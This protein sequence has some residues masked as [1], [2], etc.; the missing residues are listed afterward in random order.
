MAKRRYVFS[1]LIKTIAKP[2]V[3]LRYRLHFT[4]DASLKH[5]KRPYFIFGNHPSFM[6]PFFMSLGHT[7][8]INFVAN[9]EYFRFKTINFLLK[10]TGAIPKTKFL[11]DAVA[12]R[13][14]FRLK[15]DGSAIGVYPEG[16]RT[17][18]GKTQPLL[19]PTARL[20][21]KMGIPVVTVVTRGASTSLPR[22]AL[23]M[24]K[25]KIFLNYRLLLT[26]EQIADMTEQE[27]YAALQEA[28]EHDEP[29]WQ[30]ERMIPYKGKKLAERLEWFLYACPSCGGIETMT[31]GEDLYSCG[32]CGYTVRYNEFGFFEHPD[33]KAPASPDNLNEW[34]ALQY[35]I[36]RKKV[37]ELKPGQTLLHNPSATLFL[38]QRGK[39]MLERI[40]TG[41]LKLT[42]QGFTLT[43]VIGVSEIEFEQIDT[44]TINHK[45]TI[46][47]YYKGHKLRITLDNRLRCGYVWEC[48]IKA[49][50][51]NLEM[52]KSAESTDTENAGITNTEVA[53]ETAEII[54]TEN[55]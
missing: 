24:R 47:F 37:A 5:I 44:I 33:T 1:R 49:L 15:R 21:K 34:D 30:R 6:D 35:E 50:K 17:W 40:S 3:S 46:D 53:A 28:L 41:E 14:I 26:P 19:Y 4:R 52:K 43:S 9:D 39:S 18:P 31:S 55:Q 54:T 23:H 27:I 13:N 51:Q 2:F 36:L 45:N 48:A 12:V 11:T 7:Q 42:T 29:Q 16:G 38:G 32:Q 25:G 10:L 8:P 20:V 22:W